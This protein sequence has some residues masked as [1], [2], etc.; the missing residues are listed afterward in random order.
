M[1]TMIRTLREGERHLMY[2]RET[3]CTCGFRLG[4]ISVV[5]PHGS[6]APF[7]GH[8][9]KVVGSKHHWKDAPIQRGIE[10]LMEKEYFISAK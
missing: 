10:C 8:P 9:M 2:Y 7:G 3:D 5:W 1:N 4:V 6:R